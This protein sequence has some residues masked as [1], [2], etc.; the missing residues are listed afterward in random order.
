MKITSVLTET[1][2]PEWK[3]NR[4]LPEEDR[5]TTTIVYPT[6]EEFEPI[7]GDA[8]AIVR[9]HVTAIRN[10][11]NNDE[12]ILDGATLVA[13]PK[14]AFGG[15]TAELYKRVINGSVIPEDEVKNAGPLS[16]S[17]SPDMRKKNQTAS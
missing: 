8:I 9:R 16:S 10:L 3:G 13:A 17:P 11:R 7:A 5:V 15:L 6:I 12:P 4:K 2:V 14:Y 1:Y